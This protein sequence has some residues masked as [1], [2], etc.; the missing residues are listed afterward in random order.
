MS[1][2][3]TTV[4]DNYLIHANERTLYHG[5]AIPG[6]RRFMGGDHCTFGKG[7]YGTGE[8]DRAIAYAQLRQKDQYLDELPSGINLPTN[9]QATLYVIS[10]SGAFLDLSKEKGLSAFYSLWMAYLKENKG[11]IGERAYRYMND[12]FKAA[13]RSA[14]LHEIDDLLAKVERRGSASKQSI[15]P[16][17]FLEPH[18]FLNV[19]LSNYL[20]TEAIV[21]L[22]CKEGGDTYQD[23]VVPSGSSWVIFEPEKI[24]TIDEKCVEQK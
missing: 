15:T 21:G 11:A 19:E 5:S 10:V 9:F 17:N 16:R 7:I 22:V 23:F 13:G 24:K 4:L 1:K 8:P 12:P 3:G 2:R 6:I 20:L 14:T 18:G